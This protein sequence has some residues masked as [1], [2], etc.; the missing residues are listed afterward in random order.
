MAPRNLKP[1]EVVPYTLHEESSILPAN[2]QIGGGKY[3]RVGAAYEKLPARAMIKLLRAT[4]PR[5]SDVCTLQREAVS[6][7]EESKTWRVWIR[8][9]RVANRS[10]FRSRNL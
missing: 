1:N 7:D 5:V 4:A 2:E 6:W 8:L 10:F 9:R 3:N